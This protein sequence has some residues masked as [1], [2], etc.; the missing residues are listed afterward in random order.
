MK[1]KLFSIAVLS[2]LSFMA[3]A[4]EIQVMSTMEG[5]AIYSPPNLEQYQQDGSSYTYSND[6]NALS[7]AVKLDLSNIRSMLFTLASD[8]YE[9]RATGEAGGK[10][11]EGYIFNFFKTKGIPAGNNGSYLQN[12][13]MLFREGKQ[14]RFEFGNFTY[15]DEMEYSNKIQNDSLIKGNEI[16]FAGYGSYSPSYNDFSN[17]DI[18]DK[19]IMVFEGT[20]NNKYGISYSTENNSSSYSYYSRLS[21]YIKSKKPKAILRIKNGFEKTD[22]YYGSDKRLV[23]ND[24]ESSPDIP[25]ISINEL[26]A[27]KILEST[28]KTVKQIQ[29][30]VEKN[31]QSPSQVIKAPFTLRGEYKFEDANANNI[32]A[33]IEGSD[34]KSEYVVVSAHYDH[35][36]KQ[37]KTI[38]NGAD[39]NASGVSA[40]LEMARIFMQAKKEGKGQRRSIIFLLTTAEENGL[41][42]SQYYT[43]NPIY[44]LETTV[45]CLNIDMVG[46]I[47]T[48]YLTSDNN[49]YVY[50]VND[51]RYSGNLTKWVDAVNTGSTKLKLDYQHTSPGDPD[52]YF[53]RSDQYNFANKKVPSIMFTS[54]EH[55]DYH[56]ATDDAELIDYNGLLKRT[57][58]AFLLTWELANSDVKPIWKSNYDY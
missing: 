19:T 57:K 28:G 7:Y 52:Y 44:P 50:V 9:G 46:R 49:D 14:K 1:R 25:I 51:K 55:K 35:N 16:I 24:E 15:Y 32:V 45:A 8:E 22:S 48:P 29:F 39:D 53:S 47:A 56:K 20:P 4:Q 2:S 17:I 36:G 38:Y 40:V 27:N 5:R 43:S 21:S 31:G 42:G 3:A 54:G 18:Q 6:K 34:L 13:G 58:L 33:F 26:L 41:Y 12:I 30:E 37:N 11:A 10:K 23:F